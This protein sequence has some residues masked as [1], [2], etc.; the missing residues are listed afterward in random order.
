MSKKAPVITDR[1]IDVQYQLHNGK[2]LFLDMPVSQQSR[3]LAALDFI[4][5]CP[6][7][8]N[9]TLTFSDGH[10]ET[11]CFDDVMDEATYAFSRKITRSRLARL[12]LEG[13]TV[14]VK[15]QDGDKV[16]VSAVAAKSHTWGVLN[17]AATRKLAGVNIAQSDIV[18]QKF[19][20]KSVDTR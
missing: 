17:E 3:V 12:F 16:I 9:V 4:Y 19:G 15:A 18:Y 20:T 13:G 8:V 7:F 5:R 1:A 11:E 6:G 10:K 14:L 2:Q